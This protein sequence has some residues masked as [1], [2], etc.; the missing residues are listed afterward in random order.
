M[1]TFLAFLLQDRLPQSD[2]DQVD[3][4]AISLAV[5]LLAN[6]V[7]GPIGGHLSDRF[8]RRPVMIVSLA[9]APLIFT[10]ALGLPGY[11][12]VAGLAAGGFML[13]LPQPA[14]VVMAQEYMPSSAGTA[15]SMITG[16]AWGFGQLLC[17][18]LGVL[19][20][21]TSVE[22]ALRLI[23]WLPLLGVL[24]VLPLRDPRSSG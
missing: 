2:L 18:P 14:N 7:S 19:A 16:L 6:A 12:M 24:M 9:V 1:S 10:L 15:A 22:I 4:A 11:W 20:E 17:W 3:V 21:R 8:G 13:M 5:F 23:V